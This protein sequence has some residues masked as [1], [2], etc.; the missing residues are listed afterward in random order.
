MA[1]QAHLE[2]QLG[3]LPEVRVRGDQ[4]A[5]DRV[6]S[7]VVE[8]AIKYAAG[9]GRQVTV[10]TGQRLKEG[11]LWGWMEVADDGPGIAPEH[12]PH[13]FE[14]FYRADAARTPAAPTEQQRA[15]A[16]GATVNGAGLGLAIA[17]TIAMAHGGEIQVQSSPGQGCRVTIWLPLTWRGAPSSTV[18]SL[19]PCSG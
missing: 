11:E 17:Q 1:H 3:T 14:R 15:L 7:N 19:H 8:N 6:I 9:A 12:L 4:Q 10:E 16:D 2:L 13:I 18:V 5:L